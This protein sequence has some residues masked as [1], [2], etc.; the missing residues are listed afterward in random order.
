MQTVTI[1]TTPQPAQ[2]QQQ[3]NPRPPNTQKSKDQRHGQSQEDA[4]SCMCEMGALGIRYRTN[5]VWTEKTLQGSSFGAAY[6][7][8]C[9]SFELRSCRDDEHTET[10]EVVFTTPGP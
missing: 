4:L 1:S 5:G 7:Q 9:M 6:L 8:I 3:Q 2:Q 10:A